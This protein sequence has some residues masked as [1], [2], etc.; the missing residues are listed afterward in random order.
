MA[1]VGSR[2]DQ[3]P[4]LLA[5]QELIEVAAGVTP[6]VSRRTGL[7]GSELRSLRH[8][9][10]GPLGPVELGRRIG[11]TSAASSGIVDRL[12]S[13][14]HIERREHP[15]DGRRTEVRITDSGRAEVFAQLSPMF[16][17]L[18]AVDRSLS[19]EERPVVDRFLAGVTEAMRRVL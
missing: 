1:D 12:E 15:A 19:E 6:A 13:R 7:S 9:M 2:W 14:G 11:V 4:T 18:A 16:I 17:G 10:G 5:L 8:L 3:S